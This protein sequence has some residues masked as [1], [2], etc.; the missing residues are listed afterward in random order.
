MEQKNLEEKLE[1]ARMLAGEE[2]QK[3]KKE[4]REAIKKAQSFLKKNPEKTALI[5]AGIGATVG[6]FLAGL[7]SGKKNSKAKKRKK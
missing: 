3:I 5:S 4:L 1:K 7:V 6:A 2:A